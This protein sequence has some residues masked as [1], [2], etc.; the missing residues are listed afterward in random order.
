MVKL[1]AWR[2]TGGL[3]Q[4]RCLVGEPLAKIVGKIGP[5]RDCRAFA[6]L[7][8][9]RVQDQVGRVGVKHHLP[10]GDRSQLALAKP[11][12]YQRLVDQ[13]SFPPEPF[14]P[15][16]HF[17]PQCGVCFAFA[18]PLVDGHR[19]GQGTLAGHVKQTD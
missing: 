4:G 7:L 6:V 1:N 19:I 9:G 5:Q 13:L 18:R 2:T 15:A 3:L 17:R 11:G 14:K 10:D 12:Q 8:I 16:L